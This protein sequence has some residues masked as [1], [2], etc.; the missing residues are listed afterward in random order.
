MKFSKCPHSLGNGGLWKGI[1]ISLVILYS[2]LEWK[3]LKKRKAAV[4]QISRNRTRL[5]CSVIMNGI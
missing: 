2:R 3:E 5:D 1:K 4:V